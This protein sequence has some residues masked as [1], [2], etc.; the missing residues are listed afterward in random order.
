MFMDLGWHHSLFSQ[1]GLVANIG[2]W[3]V[4]VQAGISTLT[5]LSV[6]RTSPNPGLPRRGAGLAATFQ[7]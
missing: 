7:C 6:D 2:H 3:D 4:R 5:P 1:D